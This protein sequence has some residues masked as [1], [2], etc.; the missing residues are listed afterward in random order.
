MPLRKAL[1]INE[2][3]VKD[4][5]HDFNTPISSMLINSKL[6]RRE[7]GKNKKI[8]RLENNIETILSL[9]D[10]LQV[11]LKGVP[12]QSE[13]F[14]LNELV[15]NRV[16]YFQVLYPDITYGIFVEKTTLRTKKDA[17]RR[18]LDNIL[19]N[20]GKYNISNGDVFIVMKNG[21]LSIRDTGK[22]IKNPSKVFNRYYKE[23]DRGIGIGLHIVKKLCEEMDIK[24]KIESEEDRGTTIILDLS[25]IIA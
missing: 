9:Q 16:N 23:Q 25:N 8:D 11:F 15:K 6:L 4:I 20:A 7:I 17:L 1:H 21:F 22:G 10:N 3:F 13:S 2:E 12:T 18:V 19:S 14:G 24:L 5:L